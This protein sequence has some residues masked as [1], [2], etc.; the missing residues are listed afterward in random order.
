MCDLASANVRVDD[1]LQDRGYLYITNWY[2][3]TELWDCCCTY[4]NPLH[5]ARIYSMQRALESHELCTLHTRAC[6]IIMASRCFDPDRSLINLD[7]L[8]ATGTPSFNLSA[9]LPSTIHIYQFPPVMWKQTFCLRISLSMYLVTKKAYLKLNATYKFILTV[10]F[11]ICFIISMIPFRL[12]G[13]VLESCGPKMS[14]LIEFSSVPI[15]M[16]HLEGL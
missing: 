4:N 1:C 6:T 8:R 2:F 5:A 13:G 12:T 9:Y 3:R 14:N 15:E 7:P 16:K 10:C 11:M